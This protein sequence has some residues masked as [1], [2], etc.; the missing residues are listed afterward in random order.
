M[1]ELKA[2]VR[3]FLAE[4]V[5]GDQRE[6]SPEPGSTYTVMVKLE[7]I[8]EDKDVDR[9]VQEIRK[10]ACTGRKGDGIIAA[11]DLHGVWG[12]RTEEQAC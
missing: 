12:I 8:C 5:N 3:R 6:I 7:L 2:Y 9:F 11:S 4:E 1:K 10:T